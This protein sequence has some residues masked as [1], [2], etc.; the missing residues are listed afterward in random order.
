MRGGGRGLR[1]PAQPHGSR[2]LDHEHMMYGMD[3]QRKD[4]HH[5]TAASSSASAAP[6]SSAAPHRRSVANLVVANRPT[7]ALSQSVSAAG[8]T[9]NANGGARGS[10]V[11]PRP[12]SASAGMLGTRPNLAAPAAQRVADVAGRTPS[13]ARESTALRQSMS[14]AACSTPAAAATSAAVHLLPNRGQSVT[15]VDEW[16]KDP[17]LKHNCRID[18]H[19]TSTQ[20]KDEDEDNEAGAGGGGADLYADDVN[21]HHFVKYKVNPIVHEKRGVV[22]FSKTR[23][24]DMSGATAQWVREAA[25]EKKARE[26][27]EVKTSGAIPNGTSSNRNM[28]RPAS[29]GVLR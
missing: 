23:L 29:A 7:G 20:A 4:P 12:G 24:R 11:P 27:T 3:P 16:W 18:L 19:R 17:R 28:V 9:R 13:A 25:Q 21:F 26:V 5:H 14:A 2:F 15:S 6:A 8:L 22:G 10:G 1:P